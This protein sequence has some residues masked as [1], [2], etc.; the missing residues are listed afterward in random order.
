MKVSF[1]S[2]MD[3][4]NYTL[5]S[6]QGLTPNNKPMQRIVK[7]LV[8]KC[9]VSYLKTVLAKCSTLI[10]GEVEILGARKYIAVPVHPFRP[11]P[12]QQDHQRHEWPAI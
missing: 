11:A 3:I 7:L 2:V 5:S 9:I 10:I 12:H 4:Y 6:W 8:T 1:G